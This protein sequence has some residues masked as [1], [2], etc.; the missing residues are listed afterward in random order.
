MWRSLAATALIALAG[1]SAVGGA[2]KNVD[3]AELQRELAIA[4][5]TG[6]SVEAVISYLDQ[7]KIEHSQ[8]DSHAGSAHLG[9]NPDE[10]SIAAI[11]RNTRRVFP[12]SYSIT[13]M[14]TFGPDRKLNSIKIDEAGTGP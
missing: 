14:F 12:V 6:S 7:K 3:K 11:I 1:C 13:M 8:L 9:L 2:E 4:L 10:S 5:P